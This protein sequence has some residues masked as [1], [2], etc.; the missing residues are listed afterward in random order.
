MKK[1]ISLTFFALLLAANSAFAQKEAVYKTWNPAKDQTSVVAG[2]GWHAG[3]QDFYDRLPFKSEKLVRK[4]VW[5]LSKNS[6][7]LNLQFKS[8]APEIVVRYMVSGSVQMPHMPATGVSGVD[9][10]AKDANDGKW[11]WSAGKYSF[12][13]TIVYRF[14]NLKTADSKVRDYTLYLPLYNSV[15]WM[16]IS[17]PEQSNF[18]P[19]VNK[20]KPIVVYGTS[21]AQGACA[22][23]PGLAWTSIVGRKLNTPMVN[24]AFSGNGRLEKEL[25]ELLP[26]IDAKLYVLDCLPN[27]TGE[28][29]TNAEI[30]KRVEDAVAYLQLKKPGVPILLTEHDGYTDDGINL[31]RKKSYERVNHALKAAFTALKAK[32]VT[33]IFILTKEE[34]NQDI[35][36]TVDGTH[37]NDIGMMRYAEAYE[38]TIKKILLPI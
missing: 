23:R 2:Q 15:K 35:E 20:E 25:I 3:I 26:E 30:K 36:S 32:G 33:N 11:L 1:I 14:I 19:S 21:I 12:G 10:Y 17:V 5:N 38:K 37:P 28:A 29:F 8:D 9:L 34:I 13:D 6:S 22:S 16:E 24:L 18:T 31:E 7:G 4:P 27:L